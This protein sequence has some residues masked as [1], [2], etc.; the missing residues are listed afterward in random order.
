MSRNVRLLSCRPEDVFRVFDDG[1]LFPAWVVGTSRMRRVDDDWPREGSR[2]HHSFGVWPLATDDTTTV[3]EYVPFRRFVVQPA[4]WPMGEARVSLEL[5]ARGG[6]TRVR[7]QER[8]VSG[9]A[10][11]VPQPLLDLPLMWRNAETLRRLAHLA[12]GR[13]ASR[14]PRPAPGEWD[15]YGS[16]SGPS[17]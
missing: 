11:L 9:P 5:E 10:A 3:L 2:L 7:L 1:W 8:A 16:A 15:V 12:E 13:A 17:A 4:G 6:K 14:D